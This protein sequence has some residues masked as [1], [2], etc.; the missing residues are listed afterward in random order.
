MTIDKQA[1]REAIKD[2]PIGIYCIDKDGDFAGLKWVE[3]NFAV[4]KQCLQAQLNEP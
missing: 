3:R 2:M 4:I 1:V